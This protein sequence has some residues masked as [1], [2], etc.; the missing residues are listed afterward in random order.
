LKEW[1][2]S[3]EPVL[4][5]VG[6]PFILSLGVAGYRSVIRTA[7]RVKRVPWPWLSVCVLVASGCAHRPAVT[8]NAFT[9]E[10]IVAHAVWWMVRVAP[11]ARTYSV[12]VTGNPGLAARAVPAAATLSELRAERAH[13]RAPEPAAGAQPEVRITLTPPTVTS[14]REGRVEAVYEV[15]GGVKVKCTVRI[16]MEGADWLVTSSSGEDCWRKAK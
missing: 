14:H 13:L 3:G 4:A 2:A 6:A 7:R 8:A 12:T 9:P 10:N 1:R 15:P 16:R 5:E 11:A